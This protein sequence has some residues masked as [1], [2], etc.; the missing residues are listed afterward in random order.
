MNMQSRTMSNSVKNISTAIVALAAGP[1]F[2][3]PLL[4]LSA[5][6]GL[7]G[8]EFSAW[9]STAPEALDSTGGFNGSILI[10]DEMEVIQVNW[11]NAIRTKDFDLKYSQQGAEFRFLSYSTSANATISGGLLQLDIHIDSGATP[12]VRELAFSSTNPQPMV[13]SMHAISTVDGSLSLPHTT[14]NTSFLIYTMTSDHDGDGMPDYYESR[15][16]LDPYVDDS[17][18]DSDGDGYTNIEEYMRNS[19]PNDI[20]DYNN[21]FGDEILIPTTIYDDVKPYICRAAI[22]ITLEQDASVVVEN[23]ASVNLGAPE[24]NV[25]YRSLLS[26]ETGAI[27]KVD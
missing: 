22:S 11:G 27:F 12:G 9:L 3:A 16:G 10:P 21:C 6:N 14:S 13:N 2:S 17:N 24:V 26:V 23:G 1:L 5:D 8:S 18:I 19:D 4:F 20:H 15:Y 7:I 25:E